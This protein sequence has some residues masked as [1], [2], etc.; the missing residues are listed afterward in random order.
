MA[1]TPAIGFTSVSC[2]SGGC[3]SGAFAAVLRFCHT[4]TTAFMFF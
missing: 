3:V 4:I 2:V 1:E